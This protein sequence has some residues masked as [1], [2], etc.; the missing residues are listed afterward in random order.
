MQPEEHLR[1]EIAFGYRNRLLT[2]EELRAADAHIAV[3]EACREELAGGMD[4]AGMAESVREFLR[5]E[6]VPASTRRYLPW[7]SGALVAAAAAAWLLFLRPAPELF[8]GVEERTT[9]AVTAEQRQAVETAMRAGHLPLPEFSSDLAPRQEVLMGAEKAPQEHVELLS[10]AGTAVLGGR[11]TFR[12]KPLSGEWAYTVRVFS[13]GSELAAES[14]SMA[15]SEWTP[16]RDL[17]AGTNY[18]WQVEARRGAERAVYPQPPQTPPRFRVADAA[19][20]A[21]IARLK[22]QAVPHLV[23]AVEYARAGLLDDARRELTGLSQ[24]NPQ[25]AELRRLLGSLN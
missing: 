14:P 4:A 12:W 8:P 16:D 18:E 7:I 25:S 5:E 22:E 11:P 23:L 19:T 21:A 6:P 3:C 15:G 1:P 2:P 9:A 10:P 24:A 13:S 17:P 20:A